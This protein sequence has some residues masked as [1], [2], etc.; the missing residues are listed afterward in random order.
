MMGPPA[1]VGSDPSAGLS[2]RFL[3]KGWCDSVGAHRLR[4]APTKL[5]FFPPHFSPQLIFYF[6]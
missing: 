6:Y 2:I 1:M 3:V 5:Q 4:N